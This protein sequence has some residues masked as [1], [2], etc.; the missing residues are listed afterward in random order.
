MTTS[1]VVC[2]AIPLILLHGGGG[3]EA[4][5]AIESIPCVG[6]L[7]VGM[8]FM[9]FVLSALYYIIKSFQQRKF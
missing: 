9:L 4:R 6:G 1:A 2:G 7:S 5:K 3:S 8:L